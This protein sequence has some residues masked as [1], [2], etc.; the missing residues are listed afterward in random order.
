MYEVKAGA[1]STKVNC[2]LDAMIMPVNYCIYF[3]F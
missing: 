2:D 1:I 3:N